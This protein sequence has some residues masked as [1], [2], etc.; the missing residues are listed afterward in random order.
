MGS[1]SLAPMSQVQLPPFALSNPPHL[2]QL[3]LDIYRRARVEVWLLRLDAIHPHISGNKWFKLKYVLQNLIQQGQRSVLTF[4]GA[5]SNHIHALA[6]AGHTL[7][8][9]TVGVIR[10]EPSSAANPT[11]ADAQRWGMR[12]HFV[13]RATYRRRDDPDFLQQLHQ[14]FTDFRI[15]A[16]GGFGPLA[17][18]G[19]RDI[20]QQPGTSLR[21][22]LICTAVG[23]GATLAG[24]I[25]A[26]PAHSTL[27]GFVAL[28]G[29]AFLYE[30]IKRLLV[31]SQAP[32]PGGWQLKLDAHCGGYAKVTPKLA[33]FMAAF[34]RATGVALDPV[35]TGK[36]LLNFNQM[37]AAGEVAVGSRVLLIHSG[38][39]R[40]LEEW[41]KHCTIK[42]MRIVVSCRFDGRI[43]NRMTKWIIFAISA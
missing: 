9:E 19:C 17:L 36:M 40:G 21:F 13:D 30:D 24:L 11:L 26:R 12:L 2:Q 5:Y 37:V 39:C 25:A 8:L 3:H 22:D 27:L 34:E 33:A 41:K 4:G 20:L 14:R 32:D 23:T 35:Y 43:D 29:G 16:E 10:G 6:Y 31:Q 28:K 7:G 18:A 15:I 42:L 1:G 38:G